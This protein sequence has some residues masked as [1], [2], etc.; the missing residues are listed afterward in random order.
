MAGLKLMELHRVALG[1]LS[2]GP[3][4][5]GSARP[6]SAEELA[7]LRTCCG[8]EVGDFD[9]MRLAIPKLRRTKTRARTPSSGTSSASSSRSADERER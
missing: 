4:L 6:I 9:S 1:P 7:E 8:L 5:C 3:L 2:L